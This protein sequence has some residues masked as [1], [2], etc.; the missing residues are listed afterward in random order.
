MIGLLKRHRDAKQPL[1]A[2]GVMRRSM[3]KAHLDRLQ[4]LAHQK[5][6]DGIEAG[7]QTFC[8]EA[9]ERAQRHGFTG[10]QLNPRT[11]L[12]HF[13]FIGQAQHPVVL[14]GK[15]HSL[16]EVGAGQHRIAEDAVGRDIQAL[17]E[18]QA[19]RWLITQ[20]QGAAGELGKVDKGQ[21]PLRIAQHFGAYPR[22]G[23]QLRTRHTQF[24][25]QIEQGGSVGDGNQ[26][27]GE[28]Q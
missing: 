22:L 24:L 14:E 8:G 3:G 20:T 28:I 1:V 6:R 17:P 27:G 9:A 19:Q 10:A 25:D 16:A 2:L 26:F 4:T 12:D 7:Q 18:Q 5:A 13:Q 15:L 11:Q 23:K 21:P